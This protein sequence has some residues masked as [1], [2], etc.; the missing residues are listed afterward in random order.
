MQNIDKF[1]VK[2][3]AQRAPKYHRLHIIRAGIFSPFLVRPLTD[4]WRPLLP[5]FG[6]GYASPSALPCLKGSE[7]VRQKI[8]D[9][10]GFV[11]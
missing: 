2:S 4:I 1:Y 10:E 11:N 7:P 8:A 9:V 6:L 3:Q 5:M